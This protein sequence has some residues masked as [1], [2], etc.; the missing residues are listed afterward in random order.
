MSS[1]GRFH[2]RGGRQRDAAC[3]GLEQPLL[4][5]KMKE[6]AL[7]Q[8]MQLPLEVGKGKKMNSPLELP[9]RNA[10]LTTT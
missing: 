2:Y 10:A 9:E 5:S 7:S 8:G 1:R 3:R 4:A 6:G